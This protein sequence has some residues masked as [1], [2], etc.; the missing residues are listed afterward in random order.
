MFGPIFPRMSGK[1]ILPVWGE[2]VD[3]LTPYALGE[4]RADADVLQFA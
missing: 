1:G 4:A 3:K 2:V